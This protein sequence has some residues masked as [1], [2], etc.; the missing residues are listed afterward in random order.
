MDELYRSLFDENPDA[1]LI[2]D[3]QGQVLAINKAGALRFDRPENELVGEDLCSL[4]GSEKYERIRAAAGNA[5]SEGEC[6]FIASFVSPRGQETYGEITVRSFHFRESP[7]FH[8]RLRIATGEKAAEE[9]IRFQARML[10]AVGQA[11]IAT[12]W[13]RKIVYCN[14]TLEKL[15]GWKAEEIL[16]KNIFQIPISRLFASEAEKMA[17]C[18]ASGESWSGEIALPRKNGSFVPALLTVT[19]VRD[20]SG[21]YLGAIGIAADISGLKRMEDTLRESE[22]RY[23]TLFDYAGDAIFIFSLEGKILEVNRVA[24]TRLGYSREQ[25]LRMNLAAIDAPEGAVPFDRRLAEIREQGFSF[26]ETVYVCSDGSVSPVEVSNRLIDYEENQA[27]MSI[28]RDITDRK[29][30]EDALR[31]SGME[32]KAILTA[33]PDILFRIHRDGTFI[34][35]HV[36]RPDMLFAPPEKFLWKKISEVMPSEVSAQAIT[37]IKKAL[38]TGEMQRMEYY[39]PTGGEKRYWES[40]IIKCDEDEVLSIA[41]D[42]TGRKRAEEV[43]RQDEARLKALFRVTRMTEAPEREIIEFALDEAVGL[44]GSRYGYFCFLDDESAGPDS[45]IWSGEVRN[46]CT[47]KGKSHISLVKAKVAANR[48][49][50][51]SPD[52]RNA[53]PESFGAKGFPQGHV[54]IER[55]MR[56]PIFESGKIFAVT[57][58]ANK[59]QAYGDADT[60]QLALF[61]QG[62]WELIRRKR[63]DSALRESEEKYRRLFEMESDAIFLIDNENGQIYEVNRAAEQLYGYSRE[64]MLR[65]RNCDLSAEAEETRRATAQQLSRIPVRFHRRKDDLVFPVEIVASHFTWAGRSVHI[66]AV[67]DITDRMRV[68]VE[69]ERQRAFFQKIIDINPNFIYVL[70]REG[71][72]LWANRMFAEFLGIEPEEILGKNTLEIGLSPDIAQAIYRDDMSVLNGEREKIE[73]EEPINDRFGSIRWLYTVKQPLRNDA[74]EIGGLIGVSVDITERKHAEEAL[75]VSEEKYSKAFLSSPSIIFLS[76]LETGRFLEVNESFSKI[77]GYSPDEAVGKTSLEMGFWTTPEDRQRIVSILLDNGTVHNSEV[78]LR[79]KGGRNLFGLLSM[80]LIEVEER[81]CLLTVINDIT[82]QKRAEADFLAEK[83]RL[84][85]TLASIGDAVIATDTS[86]N[87]MLMNRVAE[88]LTGWSQE[89]ASG[90]SLA[91]V[92]CI[93]NGKTRKPCRNP[94]QAILEQSDTVGLDNHTVLIARNGA[95]RAIEDSGAPIRA[96]DGAIVGVVL[97][98]RDVT[99]KNKLEENMRKAQKLESVGILAGGIAH[100]FNNILTGIL[101]NISLARMQ[102]KPDSE[103]CK[104]LGDAENETFRAR[105]L[106][107]QLLTFSKGGAPVRKVTSISQMLWDTVQFALRGS[108]VR[109]K[110]SIPEDLW[111]AMVDEGQVSQVINNLIINAVQAMPEGGI[112]EVKADNFKVDERSGLP[113]K[114]GM[115][116]LISIADQGTGISPEHLPRI[117]DPYFTTKD[118]GHGLGLATTYS[119]VRK[120]DGHIEVESKPGKGSIFRVYFPAMERRK[121]IRKKETNTLSPGTGHI[122]LMDDEESILSSS[123]KLL[124]SLGYRVETSRDGAEAVEKYRASVESKDPFDLVIMDLTIPGGMGGLEALERLREFDPGVRAVVSSGYSSDRIMSDYENYGFV[125]VIEKPYRFEDLGMLV[126]KTLRERKE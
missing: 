86:G 41:R 35:C 64:E 31:Q 78:L 37:L 114:P 96:K 49:R 42:I 8:V 85:V 12:D 32:M 95:E 118:K 119:I 74:G 107:L 44:T 123:G 68:H 59:E 1:M 97:V 57:G 56:V 67:R 99:G 79:G 60:R 66:A 115:Y 2:F 33:I 28:A 76:D 17:G 113:L 83:E 94:V 54:P 50:G 23:R 84:A 22:K 20:E 121:K 45:F 117:F 105:D 109:S 55:H 15:C 48:A 92:F 90:V 89:E 4:L 27:V 29:Q 101:G 9:R 47:V 122:L 3:E 112:I 126:K 19:P 88:D 62:V 46:D 26:F 106:T 6:S 7:A 14:H 36:P 51:D 61:M 80:E 73:S 39:L 75:R 98:F 5:V 52:I 116:I 30:A 70:D 100:D 40:R 91:D 102:T 10:D 25:L 21:K 43:F 69:L 104:I 87:V 125:G 16:G 11:V 81:K 53:S 65:M 24:C 77:L 124:E 111:P 108:N 110:F 18:L 38:D 103:I 34:G 13:T 82:L 93:V 72:N 120:H 58:V 63:L 71:R